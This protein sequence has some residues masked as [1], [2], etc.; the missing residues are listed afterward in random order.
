MPGNQ[1]EE[2]TMSAQTI[3]WAC[4]AGAVAVIAVVWILVVAGVVLAMV[5]CARDGR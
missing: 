3:A 1:G 5:A 2:S 4:I